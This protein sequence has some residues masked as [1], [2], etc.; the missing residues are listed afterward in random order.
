MKYLIP[1]FFPLMV[2]ADSQTT[3]NLITNGD[4]NNGTTGW[5][6]QGDAQRIGDCCPGGHDFEFGDSGSIF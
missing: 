5:T 3:G 4:F 6:L 2:W 1:L